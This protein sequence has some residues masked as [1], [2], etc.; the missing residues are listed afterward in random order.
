MLNWLLKEDGLY[1]SNLH[2]QVTSFSTR[3]EFIREMKNNPDDIYRTTTRTNHPRVN[4]KAILGKFLEIP[5][6]I[7]RKNVIEAK[8]KE[9]QAL[10]RSEILNY[11]E[12]AEQLFNYTLREIIQF[13]KEN[14]DNV[15]GTTYTNAI[16]KTYSY[17]DVKMKVILI[18]CHISMS[19]VY[20][21][22]IK[23]FCEK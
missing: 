14:I 17:N 16:G 19:K 8:L 6:Y 2:K 11:K 7:D 21:G 18:I 13:N 23:Y 5:E 4:I 1:I 20:Q 15:F 12:K 22:Q 10:L 9:K 3:A